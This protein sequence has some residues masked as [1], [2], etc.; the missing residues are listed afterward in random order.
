MDRKLHLALVFIFNGLYG[1]VSMHFSVGF[2]FGIGNEFKNDEYTFTNQYYKLEVSYLL[3]EAKS[4]E[5]EIVIQ[6]EINFAEHQLINPY[7]ISPDDPAYI[8]KRERF[9]KKYSINQFILNLGIVLKKNN[10]RK[11]KFLCFM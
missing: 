1:Q 8:E 6:P 11:I 7:F 3:M 9:S 10:F 2:S 4:F 5:Y